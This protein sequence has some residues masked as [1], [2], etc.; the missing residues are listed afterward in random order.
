MACRPRL[1][2]RSAPDS[3][4]SVP[5]PESV[6]TRLVRASQAQDRRSGASGAIPP[7]PRTGCP[8]LAPAAWPGA[9]RAAARPSCIR[10]IPSDRESYKSPYG[11]G[12][13]SRLRRQV[14][15]AGPSRLV[16]RAREDNRELSLVRS[17]TYLTLDRASWRHALSLRRARIAATRPSKT[18]G[19]PPK[20]LMVQNQFET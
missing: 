10:T 12:S 18:Q 15:G 6:R 16:E 8:H 4:R 3:S 20:R 14:T 9:G 19:V 2:C 5:R 7:F 1:P 17:C 13:H 11:A